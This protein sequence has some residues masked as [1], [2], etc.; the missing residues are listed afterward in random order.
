MLDAQRSIVAR[1]TGA[2][3]FVAA[4]A[5]GI[6]QLADQISGGAP[7]RLA[8]GGLEQGA[9]QPGLPAARAPLKRD[10]ARARMR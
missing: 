10:R 1:Q 7:N 8:L 9:Q 6:G 2:E 4:F 3:R 5:D